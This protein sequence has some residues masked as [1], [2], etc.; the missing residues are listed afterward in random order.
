M[1]NKKEPRDDLFCGCM[2]MSM[3]YVLVSCLKLDSWSRPREARPEDHSSLVYYFAPFGSLLA[4]RG[5]EGLGQLRV[6]RCADLQVT[7][8]KA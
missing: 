7:P 4:R 8:Q 3:L 1:K 6:F 5:G 2:V